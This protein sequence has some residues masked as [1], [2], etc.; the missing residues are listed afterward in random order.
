MTHNSDSIK[1]NIIKLPYSHY[2]GA[3]KVAYAD[4]VTAMMAF[5]L[6]MWLL[7]VVTQEQ[8]DALSDYFNPSHPMISSTQS[9]AGGVLGGLT[10]SPEG[11]MASQ[12]N[13]VIPPQPTQQRKRGAEVKSKL[14]Q[15]KEK[16]EEER[17]KKAEEKIKKAIQENPEL[18]KLAQNII[19]DITPEG[20]RIQIVD[21]EG[22]SM[23]PSGSAE[24]FEKTRFLLSQI[25]DAILDM[26]NEISI[27]GHTDAT[28]YKDG[29]KYTNWELSA[30]RAN[31]SR[32]VIEES[33]MPADRVHNV[34]G[35]ADTEPLIIDDPLDPRNRRITMILLKE[36]ITNPYPP[37]E[38][39][40]GLV[41]G[42]EMP[43]EEPAPI[44]Q[45]PF[46]QTPGKIEFP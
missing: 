7:N 9:G 40:E 38:D 39:E 18:A 10:M 36:N 12:K 24:M 45:N 46:R 31:A 21:Q 17:F 42:E 30:D 29:A 6:L 32:R 43:Y 8:K 2:A 5:F 22:E 4:F 1:I 28:R 20:L 44:Q 41:E 25:T 37:S 33:G 13:S 34:M 23:F 27:R 26:P 16:A 14:Q 19:I 35:R 3:W 15:A 11:A